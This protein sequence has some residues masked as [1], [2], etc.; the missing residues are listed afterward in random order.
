MMK[1]LGWGNTLLNR[2]VAIRCDLPVALVGWIG[3]DRLGCAL[4]GTP[5][6]TARFQDFQRIVELLHVALL[7]PWEL[8]SQ[9]GTKTSCRG[10][11]E[12]S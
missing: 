1:G 11:K 7:M 3:L 5:P 2:H 4:P 12:C 8:G 9:D 10:R 6:Q